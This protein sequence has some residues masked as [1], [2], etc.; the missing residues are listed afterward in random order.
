MRAL[1]YNLENALIHRG[2]HG[3][4][5]VEATLLVF[6]FSLFFHLVNHF[7]GTPWRLAG[8]FMLILGIQGWIQ[9]PGA[10]ASATGRSVWMVTGALATGYWAFRVL[11]LLGFVDWPMA[12]VDN[13]KTYA[14]LFVCNLGLVSMAW[15]GLLLIAGNRNGQGWFFSWARQGPSRLERRGRAA[16][17]MTA[18]VTWGWA[19]YGVITDSDLISAGLFWLVAMALAKSMINGSVEEIFFRGIIQTKAID[20]FGLYLGIIVQACLYTSF[21]FCLNPAFASKMG[22]LFGVMGLGLVLGF[23]SRLTGSIKWA[24][25]IHIPIDL[26]IEWQNIL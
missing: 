25:A 1:I 20:R 23:V 22:F 14:Y 12:D 6:V 11:G 8:A 9:W 15:A 19:V 2:C 13:V 26:V 21:H 16:L 5:A 3:R 10:L 7:P 18:S 17:L 4:Q 24:C